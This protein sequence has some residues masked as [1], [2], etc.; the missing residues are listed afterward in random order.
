MATDEAGNT[1]TCAVPVVVAPLEEATISVSNPRPCSG[2]DISLTATEVDAATA[3]YTWSGPNN[4]SASGQNIAITNIQANQAGVYELEINT[5]EG[6]TFSGSVNLAVQET[7][8]VE[9]QHNDVSCSSGVNDL[10]L[11]LDNDSNISISSYVWSGPNS[12]QS[13]E[14]QPTIQNVTS[15]NAG[16]YRV[17]VVSTA[18]CIGRATKMIEIEGQPETPTL[19]AMPNSGSCVGDTIQLLGQALTE[20]DLQYHWATEPASGIALANA[21]QNSNQA[22]LSAPGNYTIKYWVD[23]GFCSSDT[24]RAF[25]SVEGPPDLEL[26]FS[27]DT[28]CVNGNDSI[29]LSEILG[30][31]ASYTWRGPRGFTAFEQNP[32][33]TNFGGENVGFY[34]LTARSGNGC[35]AQDSILLEATVAPEQPQIEL[36]SAPCEGDTVTLTAVGAYAENTSYVWTLSK[37]DEMGT[38]VAMN[39][40]NLE[41]TGNVLETFEAIVFVRSEGCASLFDTLNFSILERPMVDL[42]FT[43]TTY[44]CIT[45]DTLAVLL[46]N[47]G[48]AEQWI[49][50]GPN[51]FSSDS[52]RVELPISRDSTVEASGFYSVQ[53]QAANGCANTDSIAINFSA[54]INQ[55]SISGERLFC[56]G[57][58]LRLSAVGEMSV[59]ATY[60][61]Q[62]PNGFE[63]ETRSIRVPNVPPS[64]QGEFTVQGML[65]DC[66]S[67]P[68]EPFFVDI[69]GAPTL[70]ADEYD[71]VLGQEQVLNILAND[72]IPADS[73][74]AM[75]ITIAPF[76]GTATLNDDRT[77]TYQPLAE[78]LTKD[79]F[80]YEVCYT[81]CQEPQQLCDEALVVTSVNFAPEECVVATV[82][83]PNGDNKNDRFIISCLE[84]GTFPDNE[85]IIFNQRGTEVFQAKP[86]LN[87]WDGT[88]KG[89]DLPD[90]TYYYVFIPEPGAEAQKGFLTIYR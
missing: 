7:P 78:S 8:M 16:L 15:E 25:L 13:Q 85:L 51:D 47:G 41:I 65:P 43:P 28:V 73:L 61:W 57:D 88:F 17:V 60:L 45:Q 46:E 3:F 68:S 36:L 49:W 58:T 23:V 50:T 1:N 84:S 89:Q 6:C 39:T 22:I 10:Q 56:E 12:F 38:P 24:A 27:G 52:Q 75:D 34:T 90:G 87:D 40:P 20:P 9:I 76:N 32:S 2:A 79:N 5:T 14:I 71:I 82:I 72:S 53:I 63:A 44:N 80:T 67:P 4:F 54:G 70:V 66:M 35:I 29:Q 11:Q 21:N 48:E 42:S 59:D 26:A 62:G 64:L 77:V 31:A 55:L 81:I 74:T 18:G 69:L 19:T 86:Y 83:T 33:V 30:E 37:A